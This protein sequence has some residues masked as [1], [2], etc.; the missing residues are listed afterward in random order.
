MGPLDAAEAMEM[1]TI[2]A[3]ISEALIGL[4]PEDVEIRPS[5]KCTPS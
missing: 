2:N 4:K 1:I 3:K 5:E